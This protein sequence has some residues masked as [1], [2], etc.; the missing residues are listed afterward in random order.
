MIVGEQPI[1]QWSLVAFA[2]ERGYPRGA[3]LYYQCLKCRWLLP[4]SAGEN[5][6]APAAICSSMP[7]PSAS[8][9][10]IRPGCVCSAWPTLPTPN[11]ALQ[12]TPAA[13]ALVCAIIGLLGGRVC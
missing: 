2:P 9:L 13:A 5:G 8:S 3:D 12:R 6:G 1:G 7:M 10:R 4:A 11:V